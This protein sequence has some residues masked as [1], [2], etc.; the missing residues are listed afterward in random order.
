MAPSRDADKGTEQGH[1]MRQH[2]PVVVDTRNVTKGLG[3]RPLRQS[4]QGVITA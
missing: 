2:V 4:G 1:P 3:G